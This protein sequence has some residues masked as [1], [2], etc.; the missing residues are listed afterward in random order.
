M[1]IQRHTAT[2]LKAKE[3]KRH[4]QVTSITRPN[5]TEKENE[6]QI[7]RK[8]QLYLLLSLPVQY[9]KSANHGGRSFYMKEE[10]DKLRGHAEEQRIKRGSR[11]ET[12][13]TFIFSCF[14]GDCRDK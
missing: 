8:T 3:A 6:L 12:S 4:K 7:T 13:V 2:S 14:W 9:V 10:M 5:Q 1:P 11:G